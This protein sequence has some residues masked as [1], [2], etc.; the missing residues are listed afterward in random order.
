MIGLHIYQV[1]E[2]SQ[3][4][5]LRCFH[6]QKRCS[7][8]VLRFCSMLQQTA[9]VDLSLFPLPYSS[10]LL[11]HVVLGMLVACVLMVP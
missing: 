3:L 8:G 5:H 11:E 10:F 6:L 9:L 2:A 4:D 7:V 1:H